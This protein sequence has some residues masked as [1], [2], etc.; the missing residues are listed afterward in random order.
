MQRAQ[1]T[2]GNG[3]ED[4]IAPGGRHLKTNSQMLSNRENSAF[5]S[6]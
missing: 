6:F 5:L 2:S 3:E 1:D 4:R